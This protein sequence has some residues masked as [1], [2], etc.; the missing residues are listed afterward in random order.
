M[1]VDRIVITEQSSSTIIAIL[2]SRS[3]VLLFSSTTQYG[4]T[5]WPL[6]QHRDYGWVTDKTK[7]FSFT[8]S[9]GNIFQIKQITW[10]PGQSFY[11]DHRRGC[12]DLH[13]MNFAAGIH[14]VNTS[15]HALFKPKFK[16][17]TSRFLHLS[18][19]LHSWEFVNKVGRNKGT[20]F[21]LH[22]FYLCTLKVDANKFYM[23]IWSLVLHYHQWQQQYQQQSSG[24]YCCTT[25][26]RR[27]RLLKFNQD[28]TLID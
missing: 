23:T 10:N 17:L 27:W 5:T 22:L 12:R 20:F 8:T 3:I 18:C 24:P 15:I 7:Y 26:Y 16:A 2:S 21:L 13:V 14:W 19:D 9:K 4:I 25:E 1:F 6:S 11:H 28:F